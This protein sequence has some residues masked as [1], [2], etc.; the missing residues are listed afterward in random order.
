MLSN[1][2]GAVWATPDE[3]ASSKQGLRE[4]GE[5]ESQKLKGSGVAGMASDQYDIEN[6]PIKI[7]EWNKGDC[8]KD[9]SDT[10]ARHTIGTKTDTS[11]GSFLTTHGNATW[12]NT[13][14]RNA[15]PYR[16]GSS[17]TGQNTVDVAMGIYFSIRDV[18][19]DIAYDV[20]RDDF[21]PNQCPQKETLR[22]T[23]VDL[24]KDT[25][26]KLHGNSSDGIF[27]ARTFVKLTSYNP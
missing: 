26:I 13:S 1:M 9:I 22:K 17:T 16:N 3:V 11:N 14:G 25:F 23:I 19:R 7:G 5:L 24:D 20:Y 18:K 21:G 12:Y 10:Y 27:Y 15:L 2:P 8:G 4:M 6:N